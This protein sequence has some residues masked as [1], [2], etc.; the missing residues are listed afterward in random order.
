M[1]QTYS[2]TAG[3]PKTDLIEVG[4][5]IVHR[6]A[7]YI[8]GRVPD[9][10]DVED[11]IQIGTIGLIEAQAAFDGSA[12]VEFLEFAKSRIKGSIL[13]EVR[14]QSHLSRL[15]IKN[16]QIHTEAKRNLSQ[17]L[18]RA[19]KHAEI[20]D[21]LGIT[22]SEY[23]KQRAHA[24][25][26][27]YDTYFTSRNELDELASNEPS[28]PFDNVSNSEATTILQESISKL[29]QRERLIV[30]L[31]YVEEMNMREIAEVI[32]V[33]ESRISQLLKEIVKKLRSS[34]A[35]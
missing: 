28:N 5:P 33:N 32:G 22:L 23:E 16:K 19:P 1:V 31:Y 12:G 13:D 20:A 3:N 27:E 17:K 10:L 30:S 7:H 35:I 11:M 9:H 6:I 2:K 4:L 15:A 29:P 14:K 21:Y 24:D 26:L 25:R 18:S 8:H 34:I